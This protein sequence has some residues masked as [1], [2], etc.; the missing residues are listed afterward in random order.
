MIKITKDNII[1][2]CDILIE[3][4]FYILI[5]SVTF[6]I[7]L[8]EI[9]A[10]TMISAWIIKKILDR[11]FS[12]VNT[13]PVKFLGVFF[14]WVLL[15]CL[16][17][18]YFHESFRGIFKVLETAF[19]F[20]V[21]SSELKKTRHLKVA[22]CVLAITVL[23]VCLDGIY[24]YLSGVDLIRGRTLISKDYL[25]RISASFVHPNSFGIFLFMV[26][27]IL[28][29]VVISFGIGF[30]NRILY[31][32]P[33]FMSIYCLYLTRSRGA[34]L[35]FAASIFIVALLKS[36][37]IL[38]VAIVMLV[39]TFVFMP[40]SAK[41]SL[42]DS[43]DLSSGT[44][45]ERVMLWTGTIDMIKVHPVL[46]FG[47][48]TY[49][50][51]FPEYKPK[52]YADYRY[53]HNCYLQMASEIGI[54]GAFLF[55]LFLLASLGYGLKNLLAMSKGLKKDV[56][57]GIFACLVGFVL[58]A[59]VDTHFYSLTLSVFFYVLLGFYSALTSNQ[60]KYEGS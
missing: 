28:G 27:S 42:K 11:G 44:S 6:S 35:S 15:S 21:A 32:V 8:V 39:L 46:G 30:K 26:S 56:A 25:R 1:K 53:S 2:L 43:F 40:T 49:S 57:I 36:K 41:E 3:A 52:D 16:E 31:A 34:W 33:F 20:L 45:W 10:T 55:I 38:L 24:Q 14:V 18:S 47:I 5:P 59:S 54:P 51:N 17:S 7:S 4:S 19:I 37:K 22:L 13:I 48:N 12:G 58:G 23:S 9:F 29:S 60:G 50:K